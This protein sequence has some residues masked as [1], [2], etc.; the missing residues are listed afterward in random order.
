MIQKLDCNNQ[1]INI[2]NCNNQY[3]YTNQYISSVDY[4]ESVFFLTMADEM[5]RHKCDESP[6]RKAVLPSAIAVACK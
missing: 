5:I 6:I 3:I 1:Y 2:Y 4:T